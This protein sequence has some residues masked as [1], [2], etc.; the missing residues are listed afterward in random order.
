MIM[1]S[2]SNNQITLYSHDWQVILYVFEVKMKHSTTRGVLCVIG[3]FC[4]LHVC[5]Y[6]C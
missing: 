2:N 3:I 6:I 1:G 4:A 5:V